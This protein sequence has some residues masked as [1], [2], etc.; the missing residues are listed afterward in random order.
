MNLDRINFQESQEHQSSIEEQFANSKVRNEQ[1]ELLKVYHYSDDQIE[2]FSL[3]FVGK[4]Y[5]GDAG[6]FGSGIYFTD[7]DEDY[8]YGKNKYSAYLNL[9]NPLILK[10]P[11]VEDVNK[12]HGMK[13]E[14]ISQGYDGTMIWNDEK[15]DEI[16]TIFRKEQIIKGRPKGWSEICVFNPEDIYKIEN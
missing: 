10:N 8:S 7:S 3:G 11:S 15:E 1:G 13:E 16:R 12:L 5:E 2:T 6:F 14:L 9:K 4:N